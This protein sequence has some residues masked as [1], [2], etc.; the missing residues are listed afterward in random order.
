MATSRIV[1]NILDDMNKTIAELCA[2]ELVRDVRGI[3]QKTGKAG[4][5]EISFPGKNSSG[6]IVFDKH[7]SSTEIMNTLLTGLQYN[8]LL[9]DKAL[10]QA[11]FTVDDE[12]VIKER[13]VF[14]KRHNK[15]W[16]RREIEEH[17]ILEEDWFSEEEGVPIMLRVDY[18]PADHI[19]GDHAAT[20]LTISNHESCRIPMKGIITFSEFIGFILF[21]FYN[22]KLDRTVWRLNSR[23]TITELEK[24]MVH[25]NWK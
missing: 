22:L 17:E 12:N 8:I 13:L 6:S 9:Y 24:H 11:E 4:I 20:H 14:M 23:E 16:D 15:I 2:K 7:I 1:K 10:I 5:C 25:M 19:D 21:H 18:A 3:S